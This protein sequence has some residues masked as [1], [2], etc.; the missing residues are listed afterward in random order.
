M[1]TNI[2]VFTGVATAVVTPTDENGVDYASFAG[3]IDYQINSGTDAIVVCGTTGEASTLTESERREVIEF[4]VRQ[5]RKRV[6]LIAGTGCNCTERAAALSR[7]ACGAGADALLVVTPY[8]NKATQKGVIKHYEAISESVDRPIIVYNV[9]TRT[10]VNIEPQTYLSLSKLKHVCGVKEASPSIS[11][12]VRTMALC[13]DALDIYAG[14]DDMILPVLALGG[15]GVVS[16]A[17]NVVP[18]AVRRITRLF[19]EGDTAGAASAQLELAELAEALFCEVNP[20]PVKAAMAAL[21]MCSDHLRLPLTN[22]EPE[23]RERLLGALRRFRP[24][25]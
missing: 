1:P 13:G 10:C 19:S 3:I 7:F 6:P 23:N 18:K 12:V 5:V 4:A 11:Q 21:S 9:P 14:N 25:P 17:A 24:V 2:P 15:K 22:M 20:I 8:Y 16:V